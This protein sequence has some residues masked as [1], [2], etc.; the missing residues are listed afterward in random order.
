[1]TPVRGSVFK[2]L[3][4]SLLSLSSTSTR[5]RDLAAAAGKRTDG[6][7]GGVEGE[8]SVDVDQ[9]DV[10]DNDGEDVDEEEEE[11]EEDEE[12]IIKGCD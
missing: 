1:L 11:V 7:R 6:E 2:R 8:C 3:L 5:W 4:L 9:D 12:C 10:D